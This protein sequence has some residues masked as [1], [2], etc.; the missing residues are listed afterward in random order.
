MD[1]VHE[2]KQYVQAAAQHFRLKAGFAIQRNEAR[3]DRASRRPQLF[4]DADLVVRNVTENVR[5]PE[6]H[7]SENES[8]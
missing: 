2:R 7:E 8:R 3:L 4:D 1:P 6:D 5:D